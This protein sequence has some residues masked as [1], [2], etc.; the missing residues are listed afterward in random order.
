VDEDLLEIASAV[1]GTPVRHRET[2]AQEAGYGFG[3]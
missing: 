2:A 3:V 1:R